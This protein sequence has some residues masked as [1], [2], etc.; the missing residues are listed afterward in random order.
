VNNRQV[1]SGVTHLTSPKAALLVGDYEVT[2]APPAGATDQGFV[3][4]VTVLPEYAVWVKAGAPGW[5]DAA[6]R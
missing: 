5:K 3:A 6:E 1:N 2:A 4:S